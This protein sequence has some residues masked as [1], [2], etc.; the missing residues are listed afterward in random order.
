MSLIL[1]PAYLFKD[2][3]HISKEHG[4]WLL[5]GELIRSIH[6]PVS[7]YVDE[8]IKAFHEKLCDDLL[9]AGKC[10]S[11]ADCSTK[12]DDR[13]LCKSCKSWFIELKDSHLKGKNHWWHK[14]CESSQWSENPW[15]VAKYF[16]PALGSNLCTTKDSESTDLS[17]L[18]NVLEWMKDAAFLSKTRVN[19]D[20]VRKLR[21]KVRNTWAHAPQQ[22]LTDDESTE[23]FSIA[24]DFLKDLDIVGPN[25]E[26]SSCL[27][28]LEY[29]KTKGVTGN[30]LESEVQSLRQLVDD[31]KKELTNMESVEDKHRQ[32]V[33]LELALRKC[34]KMSDFKDS[35]ESIDQFNQF[36]EELKS[37]SGIPNDIHVIRE[38]IEHIRDDLSKINERQKEEQDLKSWL[39]DQLMT[40]TG[41]QAEIQKVIAF[42]K[43]E[44]AVVS[45]HG[46]PGFG[47]TAIAIQVSHKLS[48]D[49]TS[50]VVFSQLEASTNEEEMIRQLCL[51]FGVNHENDPKKSLIFRLKSIKMKV[52]LVIDNID[53]MLEKYRSFFDDFIRSLRRYSRCQII[54]TS[55]SSY[56]IPELSMDFLNVKEMEIEASIELLRK[57]CRKQEEECC[58]HEHDEFLRNLAV[59]CGHVP[60]AICIAGS[61]VDDYLVED[62]H[63]LLQD[64]EKQPM[65]TLESFE[66]NKFVKQAINLSFEK[67][68]EKE[69]EVFVR[70]SVFEGSFSEDAATAVIDNRKSDTRRILKEL[71][72]RSLIKQP[73]QH[74][75][76]IHLLIKHF[77]TDKCSNEE[78]AQAETLMVKYYL[79]LGNRHTLDSYSK[80]SFK[81]HREALKREAPN[82]QNVLKICCQ[83]E[84]PSISGVPDCLASSEIYN[85]SARLF[86]FF[87]RSIIPRPIVHDFLQRC[88]DLAKE[89]KQNA[90]KINFDCF[91]AAEE[92]NKSMSKSKCD[93]NFVSMM[94]IIKEAFEANYEEV[95]KDEAI[96][97]HYYYQ[98][99]RSLLCKSGDKLG[100]ERLKLQKKAREHL[101]ISL[102]LRE[103][104]ASTP[105][106]KA[107]Q[108]FTLMHLGNVCKSIYSSERY[109][110]HARETDEA[111]DQAETYY[112]DAIEL[113]KVN[114]GEHV[115]TSWCYKHFGDLYFATKSKHDQA[116]EMY[117]L[118]KDMMGKLGLDASTG[119]VFLLSNLGICLRKANQAKEAIEVLEKAREIAEDLA[120]SNQ[121]NECTLKVYTSLADCLKQI[122]HVDK[123]V[124][125][126]EK[127]CDNAEKLAKNDEPTIYKTKVYLLLAEYLK[128]RQRDKAINVLRKACD[129]AEK[130][131]VNDEPTVDKVEVY[132]L[133]AGCLKE[134][135]RA[136]EAIEFLEKARD[137]AEKFAK[138]DE[139]TVQKIKVYKLLAECLKQCK[140]AS[141]AIVFLEKACDNTEKLSV[142]GKPSVHKVKVYLLLAEGLKQCQRANDA[143]EV[144]E[145]AR[146]NAEKLAVNDEPTVHKIKVYLLLAECL[147]QC[148]RANEAIEILKIARDNA[149]N[150]A[151]NDEPTVHKIKVYLLLGEYLKES[152]R[153]DEGAEILEMARDNAE[154]L[155][156]NDE[157]TVYKIKA[158]TSLA[159]LYHV[160][161]NY[162]EAVH[163]AKKV[164]ESRHDHI[165]RIIKKNKYK[166]LQEILQ[167]TENE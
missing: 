59:L 16:M 51:D 163:Y 162:T 62:S 136:N 58:M 135:Q 56:S 24:A 93:A 1:V 116:V 61:L 120:E 79:E 71:F 33:D 74:R 15:E 158:Y 115:L 97:A 107:N 153:V 83:Q 14:N 8:I 119:Y 99:G 10:K 128:E 123:A 27:R 156:S 126:L 25:T 92:R 109:L 34:I 9:H 7:I 66:S 144:L 166:K 23:G 30:I 155:A 48:D 125:F 91:V 114:L 67:C 152:E 106:G 96:C 84:D 140:R 29:L 86:C 141:E 78:R 63:E 111:L 18:L 2:K 43:E 19:V 72:R 132:L 28:H 35:E 41:R 65:E 20:L 42:L 6:K 108:I 55:R 150:L 52:V 64:L 129:N 36:A 88:A 105:E 138:N 12:T 4:N 60:L 147:K 17:S 133:L 31:F 21:D 3:T 161:Q 44:K 160:L 77:L 73:M 98:Y 39:P 103:K 89:R 76:S 85:T 94:E 139:P 5:V 81:E 149:E 142:N 131:A 104:L 49:R 46:G 165:E 68:S 22:E 159:I 45:I 130:L 151:V 148:K 167:S 117:I 157:P 101:K 137:N 100:E 112:K 54:T 47:K 146:E 69:Q 80:N 121:P 13:K 87:I 122:N 11:P 38:S 26:N 110:E 127:A 32:L 164:L 82:I 95:K 134:S 37:F 40:F 145:K 154:Q 70:L 124:E 102:Q 53:N 118:A 57:H 50:L 113:S 90:I 75:Y 143:I